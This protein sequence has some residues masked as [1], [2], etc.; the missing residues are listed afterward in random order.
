[1]MSSVDISIFLFYLLLFD[2]EWLE[3]DGG[4][5]KDFNGD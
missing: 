3:R 5:V 2:F 1:M 4:L